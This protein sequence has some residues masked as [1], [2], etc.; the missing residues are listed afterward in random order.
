MLQAQKKAKKANLHGVDKSQVQ[1]RGPPCRPRNIEA[2]LWLALALCALWSE[3]C[4]A[5][6]LCGSELVDTLQFVCGPDGFYVVR[7]SGHRGGLGRRA[8]GIVE[9][10]CFRSCSLMQLEQYCA[11]PTRSAKHERDVHARASHAD[12]LTSPLTAHYVW[13]RK[14]SAAA[15]LVTP[16]QQPQQHRDDSQGKRSEGV[17]DDVTHRPLMTLPS[18]P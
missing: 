13:S 6:T 16:H 14:D 9:E 1:H 17:A 15:R 5:E 12:F 18:T 2:L 8:G 7:P 10:C 4:S 11:R 3:R